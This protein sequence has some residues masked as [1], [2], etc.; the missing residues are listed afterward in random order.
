MELILSVSEEVRYAAFD[1]F[2]LLI[3]YIGDLT[4]VVLAATMGGVK[5]MRQ[6]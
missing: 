4:D 1:S 3:K 5:T 6:T 2:I